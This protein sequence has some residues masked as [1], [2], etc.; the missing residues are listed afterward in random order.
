MGDLTERTVRVTTEELLCAAG[1][2]AIT[3]RTLEFW[4]QEGLLPKA[5][6]TGQHGKRPQWTY[7]V[8]AVDQL[9]VLLALREHTKQPDVLRVALWFRGFPVEAQ[10]AR[11]SILATLE[12]VLAVVGKEL[13]K[14][15][16]RRGADGELP[17]SA[18]EHL[19]AVLAGKRGAK[20][21]GRYVRQTRQERARAMTLLL[22]LALGDERAVTNLQEDEVHLRRM[23][24]F[25]RARR[26]HPSLRGWLQGPAEQSIE[27]FTRLVSIS[28]LILAVREA[29]EEEFET[30]RLLGR[31][32]LEGITAFS[33][34]ADALSLI[35]N[36]LGL[37]AIEALQAEPIVAVWISALIVA[38]GRS[39]EL[40]AN[41]HAIVEALKTSVLPIAGNARELAAL[42]PE[43]LH[44]QLS[45]LAKLP[46]IQQAQ[47]TRL[48]ASYQ[49]EARHDTAS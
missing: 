6:R 18:V 28:S 17:W 7:P 26:A 11:S 20:A 36:A 39:D 16:D 30:S 45:D 46:F 25:D 22:G 47:L 27:G 38:V 12:S 43:Q 29:S 35:D 41:L 1:D 24:G 14:H 32:F 3:A 21:P 5:C 15:D 13:A 4:R 40:D 34:L 33:R 44:D 31:A 23:F 49:E 2:A 48:L 37:A 8:E 42:T 9:A 19:G 10:R